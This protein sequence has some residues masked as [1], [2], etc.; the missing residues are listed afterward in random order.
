MF[1]QIAGAM[2][3]F[4]ASIV[5]ARIF[6]LSNGHALDIFTI[7]N[8]AG[9]AITDTADLERLKNRIADSLT[10]ELRPW[11]ELVGK[12]SLPRRARDV[13]DVPPRVLIDNTASNFFSV[14][15]V[16]GRDRPG[17]LHDVTRALTQSGLQI[18]TAKISTY[19]ERVV[20]VFYVKDV[21]G[22]KITNAQKQD[23]VRKTVL[24]SLSTVLESAAA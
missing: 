18:G 8:A 17:L 15:E 1:S 10:G 4:G 21:F 24:A 23:E 20:D 5:E 13:F 2:A 9:K 22:M 11:R 7:Q 16:N 12:E 19:G 6:T 3:L 14:I